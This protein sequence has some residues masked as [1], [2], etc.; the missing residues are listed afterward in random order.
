[1]TSG[2]NMECDPGAL[3]MQK[4]Y[5]NI[6]TPTGLSVLDFT[7]VLGT[8]PFYGNTKQLQYFDKALTDAELQA[9]TS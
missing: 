9:L 4:C 6:N 7:R 8:N 2:Y 5:V 1:M 3:G